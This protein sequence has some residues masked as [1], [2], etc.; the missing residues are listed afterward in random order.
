MSAVSSDPGS[1]YDKPNIALAAGGWLQ[2]TAGYYPA[3]AISL[4]TLIGDNQYILP[5]AS[6]YSSVLRVGYTAY[7]DQG[8][9]LQGSLATYTG[10][11]EETTPGGS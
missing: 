1:S 8:N 10:I 2:L 9:L 5:N 11:Y 3:T 7:D 6:G 4:A